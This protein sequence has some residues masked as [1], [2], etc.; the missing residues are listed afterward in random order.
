ML[1]NFLLLMCLLS[2]AVHAQ[3]AIT[4]TINPQELLGYDTYPQP[5]KNLIVEALALT[6]QNLTYQYGSANPASGGMDCSGTIY[7]LLKYFK[8]G[9]A[10]RPS[11][12]IY[13]WVKN[14]GKLFAVTATDFTS[15]QF[16]NLQPGDLLFWTG[17]YEIKR[18]PPITHVMIYL[19]KDQQRR[20]LMIGASDG[21]SFKGNRMWGVSVF[22]FK[23]PPAN[24]TSHFIGYSCIP[25]LTCLT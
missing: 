22:D 16:A 18:T 6:K 21:R 5:V 24:S 23:L 9:A 4:A 25:S 15:T 20:P 13:T 2:F 19:G 10:P 8:V 14:N 7:F 17:T 11:N 12:E 3:P 1:N